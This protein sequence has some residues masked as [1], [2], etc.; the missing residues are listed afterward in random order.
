MT[1]TIII[2]IIIIII[3]HLLQLAGPMTRLARGSLE[4]LLE[5][6]FAQLLVLLA[7]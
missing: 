1:N 4:E 7:T 6:V 5:E 3:M 2:I